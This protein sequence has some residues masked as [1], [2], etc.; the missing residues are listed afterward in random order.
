MSMKCDRLK[1]WT[2]QWI[3]KVACWKRLKKKNRIEYGNLTWMTMSVNERSTN[4]KSLCFF[5]LLPQHFD[6]P[7]TYSLSSYMF[8][9]KF[10]F[11]FSVIWWAILYAFNRHLSLFMCV[12]TFVEQQNC[13]WYLC[14]L[15]TSIL[16]RFACEEW[17]KHSVKMLCVSKRPNKNIV[18]KLKSY[19][20]GNRSEKVEKKENERKRNAHLCKRRSGREQKILT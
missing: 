3:D 11:Q 4:S 7:N 9:V 6:V 20:N 2:Y 5:F 14:C 13:C 10:N 8:V 15:H 12:F 17:T 19:Q 1:S 16:E 18:H